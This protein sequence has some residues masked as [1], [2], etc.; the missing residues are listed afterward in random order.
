MSCSYPSLGERNPA[1][2]LKNDSVI[3]RRA[4]TLVFVSLPCILFA[5]IPMSLF[6]RS[7][8]AEVFSSHAPAEFFEEARGEGARLRLVFLTRFAVIPAS[9]PVP[10]WVVVE[11]EGTNAYC[12]SQTDWS[13]SA[14]T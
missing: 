2:G 1:A 5:N 4:G 9:Q 7:P 13:S 6:L 14:P 3:S 10:N 8:Q 11:A 12:N